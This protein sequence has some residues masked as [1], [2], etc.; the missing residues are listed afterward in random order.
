MEADALEEKCQSDLSLLSLKDV[1]AEDIA[2]EVLSRHGIFL[3][4][5]EL[6]SDEE[7]FE[8]HNIAEEECLIKTCNYFRV[9]RCWFK[10]A[11]HMSD[12]KVMSSPLFQKEV[13]LTAENLVDRV[14]IKYDELMKEIIC[15]AIRN[16]NIM[17]KR[18][19]SCKLS[20]SEV[21]SIFSGH[22]QLCDGELLLIAKFLKM[23]FENAEVKICVEKINSVF[24]IQKYSDVANNIL[25]VREKLNLQG[26][27]TIV[28]KMMVIL[29]LNI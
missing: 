6:P 14:L 12:C 27:F 22:N 17:I 7:F 10:L 24:L 8:I 25:E 26:E 20:P 18:I 28:E 13:R 4:D 5:E 9:S 2:N 16:L 11:S 1:F 23:H 21:I 19:V 29:S 15:P 3:D